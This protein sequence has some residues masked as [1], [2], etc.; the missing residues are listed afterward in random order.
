MDDSGDTTLD[1]RLRSGTIQ[2]RMRQQEHPRV[3]G[4]LLVLDQ[5]IS[6]IP[7]ENVGIVDAA[8]ERDGGAVRRAASGRSAGRYGQRYQ[9]QR[10]GEAPKPIH[11]CRPE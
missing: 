5:T 2:Q 1:G 11:H 9:Q 4:A 7:H 10:A 6:R 8:E 3:G